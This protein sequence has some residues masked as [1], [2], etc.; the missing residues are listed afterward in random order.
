MNIHEY[1]AK[2]I[3]ARHGVPV[4][5]GEVAFNASEVA[6]IARRLGGQ[7]VVVKA[8]IHSTSRAAA[9][10][11]RF[12]D[13]PDEAA[14]DMLGSILASGRGARLQSNLVFGKQIAQDASAFHHAREIAGQF[15][16]TSTARPGK[17]LE[18]IEREI[19]A[20]IERIKKEPPTAEEMVNIFLSTEFEG[21]RTANRKRSPC[22]RK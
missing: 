20:E 6:A 5:R 16:V 2:A 14:L 7:V 12:A 8:Q 22:L 1:Q 4:P 15:Q 18:E 3:L 13:S 17:T 10:G 19:N 21:G 11:I 9:G